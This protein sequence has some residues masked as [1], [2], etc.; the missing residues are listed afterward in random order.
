ML[1]YAEGFVRSGNDWT[2]PLDSFREQGALPPYE[3]CLLWYFETVLEEGRR[4]L[5]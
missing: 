2:W 3:I 1:I 4:C 5:S